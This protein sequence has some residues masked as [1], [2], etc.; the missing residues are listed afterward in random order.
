[1]KKYNNYLCGYIIFNIIYV[2]LIGFINCIFKLP[3]RPFSYGFIGLS[4]I[5]IIIFILLYKKKLYKKNIIDLLLVIIIICGIISVLFAYKQN[6][7]LFGELKRHEGLFTIIY[8]LSLLLISGFLNKKNKKIIVY[9][10]ITISFIEIVYAI[11]QKIEFPGV[12]VIYHYH[13]PWAT[14]FVHNPNFLGIYGLIGISYIIGLYLEEKNEV[15]NIIYPLL[16]VLFMYGLCLADTLSVIVGLFIVMMIV[17]IYTIKNHLYKKYIIVLSIILSTLLFTHLNG[18]TVIV[19]DLI[20]TKNESVSMATGTA[21]DTIDYGTGR[22]YI[23]GKTINQVPKYLV[24]G[25]GIDN[26][27][28][29]LDGKPI[30][31]HGQAYDKAHNELL[32]TLVTEGL[33][34][35]LTYVAL[36]FI[37]IKRGLKD[38][39][40]NKELYY[41]LPV[42]GYIVQSMF[43]ISVITVAPIFYIAIGLTINRENS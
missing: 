41:I 27:R 35:C 7:A 33:L 6:I 36:Y 28:Y 15:M 22:I 9:S 21:K 16:I 31:R 13:N 42:I 40:K 14:G 37:I 34:C 30:I 10:I 4:I 3:Q 43:S 19:K 18:Q 25:V 24:H 8:Y 23:W 26:Y 5:N 12:R 1:M 20:K 32:Q 38:T 17:L 29:I 11:F 2:F 39:F